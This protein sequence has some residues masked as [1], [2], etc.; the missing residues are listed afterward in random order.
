LALAA[1]ERPSV[2]RIRSPGS[3]GGQP[4]TG[5]VNMAAR[6]GPACCA[7]IGIGRGTSVTMLRETR[8]SADIRRTVTWTLIRRGACG[9]GAFCLND[10]GSAR[11]RVG[12]RL[13]RERGEPIE[14]ISR[15]YRVV[16]VIGGVTHVLYLF[17]GYAQG[18]KPH[19]SSLHLHVL[20]IAA[21]VRPEPESNSP[22]E[23]HKA[24]SRTRGPAV[25]EAGT[26]A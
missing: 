24:S 11:C 5:E 23:L 14:R 6:S 2:T 25:Q 19:G 9:C 20:S 12:Q 4:T 13:G 17:R 15:V 1:G 18:A 26:G 16:P 21:S 7:S 10:D 3:V 22:E 8:P